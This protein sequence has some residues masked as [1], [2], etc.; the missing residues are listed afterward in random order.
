MKMKTGMM[1]CTAKKKQVQQS[2]IGKRYSPQKL[3][4][5][6]ERERKEKGNRRKE[7]VNKLIQKTQKLEL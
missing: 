7:R 2:E 6:A 5:K 1:G 4:S 3:V